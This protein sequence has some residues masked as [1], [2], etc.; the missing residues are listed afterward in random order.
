ML[1][2][3]LVKVIVLLAQQMNLVVLFQ[4]KLIKIVDV[5]GR[6][7]NATK[8]NQLFFYIYDDGTGRRK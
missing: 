8:E 2:Y 5:Y 4:E 1:L 7:I 6:E 3:P